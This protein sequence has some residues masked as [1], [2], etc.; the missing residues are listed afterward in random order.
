MTPNEFTCWLTDSE[1]RPL[2]MGILN[3]TPDSFSDGGRYLDPSEA[4]RAGLEMLQAGADIL[5]IGGESTRP[6]SEPVRPDEQI[7]RVEAV[8]RGLRAVQDC[9]ISIDTGQSVVAAAAVAAGATL[10]NDV[11]AGCDDPEMLPAVGKLGVPIVLGHLRGRPREMMSN[12]HYSD[13]VAE[14]RA[15]LV[16]RTAA[17]RAAGVG[18]SR[19]LIDPGIGFSKNA[20][21]DLQI[22]R[23]LRKF[24]EPGLPVVVGVSRKKFIGSITG[25]SAPADRVFG[26][27]A[28]VA[29]SVANGADIVRVHD[30]AAMSQVVRMIEAIQTQTDPY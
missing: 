24:A 14:V 2:V 19:V 18:P 27:A 4:T 26:T 30:V 7:R 22:L 9:V 5:D 10:V 13:V 3:I 15:F 21:H 20:V 12:A 16:E 6:G 25:Q 28:A 23:E 11:Y 1:R 8:V 17:A 29:W